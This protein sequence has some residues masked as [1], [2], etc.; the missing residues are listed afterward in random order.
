MPQ[1]KFW[2]PHIRP[3]SIRIT[4]WLKNIPYLDT[5]YTVDT[6]G[7]VM[8]SGWI[9]DFNNIFWEVVNEMKNQVN[10]AFTTIEVACDSFSMN[11]L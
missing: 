9:L 11:R 8:F 3:E 7:L 10:P 5:F 1:I 2:R 4:A 6:F